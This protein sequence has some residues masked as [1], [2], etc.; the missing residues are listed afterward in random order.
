MLS[1]R[2]IDSTK[3]HEGWRDK[4]YYDS[5]G[6]PTIGYGTNLLELEI[7]KETGERWLRR[8]LTKVQD[9][10]VKDVRFTGIASRI[11]REVLIE[12]GY[13]LGVSGLYK[14]KRM[15]SAIA[16]GDFD[17]A[18]DEALDSKWAKQ[19]GYRATRLARKLRT[20]KDD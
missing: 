3:G 12:M 15:W 16:E 6:I 9:A 19:V 2:L 1:K 11:R 20:G 10:L 4:T 5:V 17:A 14:F 7:T 13:N 8:D 18:A